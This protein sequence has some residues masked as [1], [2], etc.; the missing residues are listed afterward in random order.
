MFLIVIETL[1]K[2]AYHYQ[3]YRTAD[4]VLECLEL[5]NSYMANGPETGALVP[6]VFAIYP[7]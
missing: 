7:R 2:P 1:A 6:D 5:M 4:T 3:P